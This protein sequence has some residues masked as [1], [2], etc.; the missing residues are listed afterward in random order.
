MT[1]S[2]LTR[3]QAL[4]VIGAAVPLASIAPNAVA[5][6][7][8][9]AQSALGATTPFAPKFFS[10]HEWATVR[11]LVDIIIPK[12]EHS[13][14]ATDAAVPEFMDFI[15]IAYP[16]EQKWVREGLAW[17]DDESKRRSKKA[18][19]DA[20]ESQRKTLL[21]DIAFPETAKPEVKDGV[22][23]FNSFRDF[24][25]SGFYSSRMG[26]DDLQ[27]KGNT[28][29]MEWKGCPDAVLDRLGVHY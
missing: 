3:R 12:D 15:V 24:T 19:V 25:A 7:V 5:H 20:S 14:S 21:N 4:G 8:R 16:E 18:F 10:A 9:Q 29:V 22:K 27:Y 23:F 2:K 13:G 26:V 1:D 28:F 17:L 6:A 11:T